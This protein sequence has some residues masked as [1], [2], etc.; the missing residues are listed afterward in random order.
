MTKSNK[1]QA[2]KFLKTLERDY[3]STIRKLSKT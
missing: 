2:D 1:K 3:A